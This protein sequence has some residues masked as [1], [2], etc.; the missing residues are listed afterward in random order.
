[1]HIRTYVVCSKRNGQTQTYKCMH[2]PICIVERTAVK[3]KHTSVWMYPH[4]L[5]KWERSNI[6]IQVYVYT[7][8]PCRKKNCQTQTYIVGISTH[9]HEHIHARTTKFP[10]MMKQRTIMPKSKIL[11]TL[12]KISECIY[13][14]IRI[15]TQAR[16][17]Q[18]FSSR[19]KPIQRIR[20]T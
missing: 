16:S 14:Y 4:T 1:M 13:V 19:A 5:R 3:L 7:H 15:Y 2:T 17:T 20:E 9:T 18:T 11:N 6:N 10:F 8:M 12:I